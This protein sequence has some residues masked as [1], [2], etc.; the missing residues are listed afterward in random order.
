MARR[1][2]SDALG[3]YDVE[4][5]S[6]EIVAALLR[7]EYLQRAVDE[8]AILEEG[9]GVMLRREFPDPGP[10]VKAVLVTGKN[11][12]TGKAESKAITYKIKQAQETR[13]WE[14]T[15]IPVF[16]NGGAAPPAD[17]P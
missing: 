7:H 10:G 9:I 6:D 14:A 13:T 2:R 17:A 4:C 12:S 11:P 1:S 3:L 15:D 8:Q 5:E 16:E